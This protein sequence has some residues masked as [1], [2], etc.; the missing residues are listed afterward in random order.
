[1]S[2]RPNARLGDVTPAPKF[3]QP[4]LSSS[5]SGKKAR[6]EVLPESEEDDTA[7]VIQPMGRE[8]R[9]WTLEGTCYA[10]TATELDD[11]DGEIVTL[12]HARHSGEV[13]VDGVD[14]D[15]A[16]KKDEDG[17]WYT[18]RIDLIEVR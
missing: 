18:Y 12:R 3:S 15:P 8:A 2:S 17:W 11:L 6:L 1:M 14:T 9:R 7:T 4:Q 16:G 13:Y 5:G 10:D